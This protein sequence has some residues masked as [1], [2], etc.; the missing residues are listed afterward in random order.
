LQTLQKSKLNLVC[1]IAYLANVQTESRGRFCIPG[2][3]A[4]R[5]SDKVLHTLHFLPLNAGTILPP[6]H[7]HALKQGNILQALQKSKQ[8]LRQG[9]ATPATI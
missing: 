5:T 9:F 2:K 4:N 8:N 3:N 1:L 7:F 6:L